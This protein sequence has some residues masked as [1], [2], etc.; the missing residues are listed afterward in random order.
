MIGITLCKMYLVNAMNYN[1][2]LIINL[3]VNDLVPSYTPF[4]LIFHT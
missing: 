1:V 2:F 4:A 3:P